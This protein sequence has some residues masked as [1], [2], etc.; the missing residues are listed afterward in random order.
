MNVAALPHTV[1]LT[2]FEFWVCEEVAPGVAAGINS[3]VPQLSA[4][5]P[6]DKTRNPKPDTQD[7]NPE[8]LTPLNPEPLPTGQASNAESDCKDQ[9]SLP[10]EA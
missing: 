1:C 5:N 3:I 4:L 9:L 8:T 6:Q 2:V 7:P 10:V